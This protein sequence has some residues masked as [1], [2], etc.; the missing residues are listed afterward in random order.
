MHS[1]VIV[2]KSVFIS[3]INSVLYNM[4][5]KINYNDI[6]AYKIKVSKVLLLIKAKTSFT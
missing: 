4:L 3:V 1:D 5:C 2:P 6:A